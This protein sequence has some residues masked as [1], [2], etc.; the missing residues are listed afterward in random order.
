MGILGAGAGP[1]HALSLCSLGSERLPTR[2]AENLLVALISQLAV[3]DRDLA[4]NALQ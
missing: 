1:K 3:G 4:Q 2:A